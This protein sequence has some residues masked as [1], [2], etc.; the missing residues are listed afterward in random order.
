MA[1]SRNCF[2]LPR[3]Q[4]EVVLWFYLEFKADLRCTWKL[5]RYH[6]PSER[7]K[8]ISMAKEAQITHVQNKDSDKIQRTTD[9]GWDADTYLTH[10][11]H[12]HYT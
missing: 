5:H 8:L 7:N 11:Q 2:I 1:L 12:D 4:E 9:H 3:G 10:L 6:R